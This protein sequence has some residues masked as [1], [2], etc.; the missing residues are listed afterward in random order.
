M[1]SGP[2]NELYGWAC[3]VVAQRTRAILQ[4][5][6]IPGSTQLRKQVVLDDRA[7]FLTAARDC[8]LLAHMAAGHVVLS[9]D[10]LREIINR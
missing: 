5:Y 3:R 2:A 4:R 8:L 7:L 9:D 10:E 1:A 6:M